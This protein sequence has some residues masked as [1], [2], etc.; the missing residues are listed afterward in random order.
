MGKY[1]IKRILIAIP[2]LIGITII[3]Y[4]IMC[5]AG[6]PLEMLQGPRVSEAAV[7]AKIAL[8]LDKPF[9]I[10]YF[11]WL[12]QLLH[13]NM[14]YSMKSY[15]SVSGMIGSH[16]GPTLLLM[17]VSLVV[18]LLWRCQPG[19]TV[20]SINIPREIMRWSHFLFWAAVYRDFF[21]IAFDLCIYG[22]TGLASFKRN[23][24]SGNAGWI[25]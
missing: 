23:D 1:I 24:D 21:I 2:V 7:E 20:Q 22:K 8:G 25:C 9:Y 18:S 16:L 4:A 14:G 15:Q 6:S 3:D 13:G 11:V 12:E 19:S 17:G 5:M 10:Q